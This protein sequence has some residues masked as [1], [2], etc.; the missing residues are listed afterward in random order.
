MH[1]RLTL[2]TLAATL[3][4]GSGILA[5]TFTNCNPLNTT[6]S[7]DIALGTTYTQNFTSSAADN[8]IW[9]LTAGNVDW[10]SDGAEF[11]I[12]GKGDSPTIQSLFYIFFGRVTTIMKAAKG[13]GIVSSIVL[14]SDD[15][16]EV[17]W[18]FIGGNSTYAETNFF[19]KGR[20]RSLPRIEHAA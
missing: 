18:E 8:K 2:I 7:A 10:T 1:I 15:L 4:T 5:Q 11:T 9:N 14:E 12:N 19:G 3:F 16:D 20:F 6:C 13:T 17:D